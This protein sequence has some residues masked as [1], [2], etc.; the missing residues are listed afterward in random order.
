MLRERKEDERLK[1]MIK[2][3]RSVQIKFRMSGEE[4]EIFQ[5][6]IEKSGIS[7]Q[8]YLLKCALN[9]S[10]TNTDGVKELLPELKRQGANLNQL[11]KKLNETGFI[12]Y[13]KE[14]PQLEKELKEIWQ[15][16]KQYLQKQA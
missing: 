6:Q 10:I 5:S 14:L 3:T 9:K 2:R 12:D 16:L 11:T 8:E 4:A 7:Q 13:K 1:D 15:L